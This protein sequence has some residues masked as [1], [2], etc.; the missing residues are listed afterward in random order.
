MNFLHRIFLH[1]IF[2]HIS[3]VFIIHYLFKFLLFTGVRNPLALN[4]SPTFPFGST[5]SS[6]ILLTPNTVKSMGDNYGDNYG[7]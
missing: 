5:E 7:G 1:R 3:F 2:L 4:A 6:K